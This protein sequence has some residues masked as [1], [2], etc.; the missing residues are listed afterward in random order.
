MK[1]YINNQYVVSVLMPIYNASPT[2]RRALNSVTGQTLKDIE[3]IC[4]NDGS[5]DD[6]PAIIKEYIA[7]DKRIKTIDKKNSGYGDSMNRGLDIATGEYI[8]ILEPDDFYEPDMLETLYNA[9]KR[10]SLDIVKAD[11][12]QYNTAQN[13]NKRYHLIPHS[14]ANK[15]LS[16]KDVE[17]IYERQPSIWSAIYRRQFLLKNKIKFQTTPGASYQDTSFNFKA[18]ASAERV[19]FL[20]KPVIN[21][22]VDNAGSSINS[23]NNKL[24]YIDKEYDEIDHFIDDKHLDYLRPE[25]A[26]CRYITYRW[27]MS[28]LPM[29]QRRDYVKHISLLLR[30]HDNSF[31]KYRLKTSHQKWGYFLLCHFPTLY[32]HLAK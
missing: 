32:N 2:L 6:S 22:R 13:S 24:D 11:F 7:K 3:I 17:F 31:P 10:N 12:Y 28:K 1:G 27:A 4:I 20:D 9:A 18:F 16:G 29:G 23:V 15:T 19:M 5:A 8:A 25:A 26:Y 30:W 14:K 21:Y